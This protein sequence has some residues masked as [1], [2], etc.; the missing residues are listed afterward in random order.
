MRG[1]GLIGLVGVLLAAAVAATP[2][3]A[4]PTLVDRTPGGALIGPELAGESLFYGEVGSKRLVLRLASTAG[5]RKLASLPV[6]ATSS[7]NDDDAP[8]EFTSFSFQL[9]ASPDRLQYKEAY[10]VGNARYQQS[11]TNLTVFGGGPTGPFAKTDTCGHDNYNGPASAAL[12]VDGP[13]MAATDCAGRIIIRDHTGPQP[14]EAVVDPG[15]GLAVGTLALAGRYVAYN[16][17][18]IGPTGSA[19]DTTVV[20]DW[21]TGAKLYEIPRVNDFDLQDN[22]TLAVSTGRIDDTI[23]CNGKLAWYSAAEPTEHVLNATKPCTS[24]VRIA[25]G[26]IAAVAGG[27]DPDDRLIAVT[28]LGDDRTDVVDLGTASTQRGTIDF[29]G[30]RVAYGVGNCGGGADLLTSSIGDPVDEAGG[31]RCPVRVRSGSTSLR[32]GARGVPVRVECA[33]GCDAEL[34]ISFRVGRRTVVVASRRVRVPT[35]S[36]PITCSTGIPFEV[37][38]AAAARSEIRRRR[39]VTGTLTVAAR[40]VDGTETVTKRRLTLRASATRKAQGCSG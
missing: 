25:G 6:H 27:E 16:A 29:D 3:A 39:T 14:T 32:R 4:A 22:G 36:G 21:T 24:D 18:P 38:L 17:N 35:P 15:N 7:G 34:M 20:Q 30:Q 12:D 10:T 33:V 23:A 13:R 2:A 26:R 19:P 5:E 11:V 8:G 40:N 1:R 9:A 28:S 31:R 37:K